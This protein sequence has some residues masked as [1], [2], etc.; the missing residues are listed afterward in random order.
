MHGY[1]HLFNF[2][3][4]HDTLQSCKSREPVPA[5][6]ESELI[7]IGRAL[8]AEAIRAGFA[9]CVAQPL[10]PG[11]R[12]MK[13]PATARQ[14][15]VHGATATKTWVRPLAGAPPPRRAAS[16]DAGE[17]AGAPAAAAGCYQ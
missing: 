3:G 14:F 5:A 12:E 11:W 4:V 8:D 9:T 16:A 2:Q 13:D 10:P 6:P 17:Q 1:S 7:F 15:Y